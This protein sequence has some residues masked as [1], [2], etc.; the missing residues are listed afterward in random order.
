MPKVGVIAS[1]IIFDEFIGPRLVVE[2]VSRMDDMTIAHE[3]EWQLMS[4]SHVLVPEGVFVCKL[5]E[6]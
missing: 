4:S 2:K 6:E 1:Q 5:K 3:L